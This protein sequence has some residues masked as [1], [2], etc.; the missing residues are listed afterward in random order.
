MPAVELPQYCFLHPAVGPDEY[1]L[2]RRVHLLC[3]HIYAK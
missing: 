2:Q 3:L 1:L